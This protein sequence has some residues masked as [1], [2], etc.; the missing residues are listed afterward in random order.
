MTLQVCGERGYCDCGFRIATVDIEGR[1][2]APLDVRIYSPNL[3]ALRL[4]AV[5]TM[6]RGGLLL[7]VVLV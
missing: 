2:T 3:R 1:L 5:G 7:P 6:S 4:S